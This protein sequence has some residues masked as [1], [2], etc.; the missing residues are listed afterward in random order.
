MKNKDDNLNPDYTEEEF[1]RFIA[2]K[3]FPVSKKLQW[4]DEMYDFY[5]KY[6]PRENKL[7]WQKLKDMGF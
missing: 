5:Q 3:A 6:T 4:L 7:K 1:E 2:Y